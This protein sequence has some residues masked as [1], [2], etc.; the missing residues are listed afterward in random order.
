MLDAEQLE[1]F[2]RSWRPTAEKV[3]QAVKVV[4]EIAIP[5]RVFVFGSWARGDATLNS[6][7]D[8]AV[9]FPEGRRNQIPEL[10]REIHR[11]L[12]EI[13]MSIDLVMV[14]EDYFL[15]FKSSINS[16]Y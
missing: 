7:L 9:L 15:Q 1:E 6:D 2:R 10:R 13:R 4:I 5:S 8:L 3:D 12:E 16:I 11:K 14:P